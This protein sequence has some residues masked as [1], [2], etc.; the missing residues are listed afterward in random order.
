[1]KVILCDRC[2]IEIKENKYCKFLS[3]PSYDFMING[4]KEITLCR[5][6]K[7]K[8]EEFLKNEK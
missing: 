7:N 5:S 3:T 1:M 8:L 6:C 2:N 4:G